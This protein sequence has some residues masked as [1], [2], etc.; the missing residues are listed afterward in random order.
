MIT[1]G[2][3]LSRGDNLVS[4][5]VTVVILDT[6]IALMAGIAIFTAVFA[7]GLDPAA[8]PALIFHVLPTVFPQ[9]PGGFFFGALFFILLL[10]AALTSGI[11]LLEVVVAYFVDQKG[12]SRKRATLLL[13]SVIFALG[14]PSALSA[15]S[16][17]PLGEFRIFLGMPFFDLMDY[18]SFKYM[19]P[20]GGFLMTIFVAYVWG[21]REF[22]AE[23]RIGCPKFS[24]RPLAAVILITISGVLILVTLISGILGL[25]E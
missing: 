18:M 13:G 7:Q 16:S 8:G 14:V 12:W 2:S 6:G 20:L 1:Y 24:I 23:L 4:A 9:I 3:Y 21:A 5:A 19:L 11:S 15:V 22:I 10:I 17:A 25:G